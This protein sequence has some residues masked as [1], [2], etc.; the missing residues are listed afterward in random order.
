M[1]FAKDRWPLVLWLISIALGLACVG[2]VL[3]HVGLRNLERNAEVTALHHAHA[4]RQLPSRTAHAL[5]PFY[6]YLDRCTT[7]EHRLLVGGFA[8]EVPVL[9]QRAFAG[10][11]LGFVQGYYE[12]ERY[13]RLV[14]QRLARVAQG[15]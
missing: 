15:A 11:Q 7:R 8:P 5:W 13:Q 14:L 3:R 2:A 10:G 1:L 4:E 9:T 6:A 12:G